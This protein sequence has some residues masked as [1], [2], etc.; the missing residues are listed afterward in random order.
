MLDKRFALIPPQ[1]IKSTLKSIR[2]QRHTGI[3]FMPNYPGK[4]PICKTTEDV[5]WLNTTVTR[6]CHPP[7]FFIIPFIISD[8]P[9]HFDVAN[10]DHFSGLFRWKRRWQFALDGVIDPLVGI[11]NCLT[12]DRPL[13][14]ISSTLKNM[15]S[16]TGKDVFQSVVQAL[17]NLSPQGSSI[18]WEGEALFTWNTKPILKEM[19]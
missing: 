17:T 15:N 11:E 18:L 1:Y 7:L 5:K 3:M 6:S 14:K 4:F 9:P 13:K 8:T 10:R 2:K 12:C 16:S 19:S